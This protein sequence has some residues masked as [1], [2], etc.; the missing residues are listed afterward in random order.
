MTKRVPLERLRN[1]SKRRTII[2][3]E[4]AEADCSAPHAQSLA[5]DW[6]IEPGRRTSGM[7]T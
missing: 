2:H 7:R 5:A 1:I 4:L 3:A 6:P